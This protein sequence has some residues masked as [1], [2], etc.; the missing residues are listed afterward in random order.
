MLFSKTILL[1]T[2]KYKNTIS[3]NM[4]IIKTKRQEEISTSDW[5]TILDL[6]G[7]LNYERATQVPKFNLWLQCT[8]AIIWLTGKRINEVLQL[9]RKHITFTPEKNPKEVRI[10]FFVGK[11]KSRGSPIELMPYQ[12][13]RTVDHKAVPYIQNYL[14]DFDKIVTDIEDLERHLEEFLFSAKTQPRHRTVHTKFENRQGQEETRTYEYDDLGGHVYEEN[15]RFW[16]NKINEQLPED[17]H[18]YF[19]YGRHSIGI[20]LAYQGRT[21]Y[22]IAEILDETVNA[23]IAYTKHAGGYSQ[24]WTKETE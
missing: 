6:A 12:K 8:L 11:K 15:A 18:I 13:T 16:L 4:P 1:E 10:K 24:E 19:H 17:K 5:K 9:R 3:Q 21:P 23:A 14:N 22:Q 7:K 2:V 20:K